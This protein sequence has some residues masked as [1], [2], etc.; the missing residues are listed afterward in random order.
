M[1]TLPYPLT[2]AQHDCMLEIYAAAMER[3]RRVCRKPALR[4]DATMQALVRA[5][6]LVKIL[7]PNC[8]AITNKGR[9]YGARYQTKKE[10]PHAE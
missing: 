7:Q 9:A 2:G 10:A 1:T 6:L 8:W 3:N 5:G 4:A